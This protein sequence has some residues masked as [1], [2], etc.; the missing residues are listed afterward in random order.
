VQQAAYPLRIEELKD[1]F[2]QWPDDPMIFSYLDASAWVKRYYQETGTPRVQ[3]LFAERETLTCASLGVVEVTATLARKT[4][5]REMS[6][7][8]LT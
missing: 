2:H 7:R 6:R 8:Q 4:K 5:A 3:R 1:C